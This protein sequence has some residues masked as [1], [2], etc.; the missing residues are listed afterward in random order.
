M[1][2]IRPSDDIRIDHAYAALSDRAESQ[3][4]GI[5]LGRQYLAGVT[6]I[7]VSGEP[8][9]ATADELEEFVRRVH[10]AG[11]EVVMD[12]AGTA[13]AGHKAERS[14]PSSFEKER[15]REGV[16]VENRRYG[17][18]RAVCAD[19]IRPNGPGLKVFRP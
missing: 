10:R 4:A 12:L 11:D 2:H 15:G 5:A 19:Q 9:L 17:P 13:T 7:M 1:R 18:H 16:C 14:R 8:D 6:I 3:L